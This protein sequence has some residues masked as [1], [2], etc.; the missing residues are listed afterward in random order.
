MKFKISCDIEKAAICLLIV[1]GLSSCRGLPKNVRMVLDAAG[2]NRFE[3]EK[4]IDNYRQL[5]A[6]S[7]KLKAAF[8]LIGSMGD[9]YYYDGELLDAYVGYAKLFG[10]D[11]ARNDIIMDSINDIHG[12]LIINRLRIISDMESLNAEYLINNIDMAFRVW[13]EQ[14][15]N[16]HLSFDQFCEYIL[17]Y[18]V[19][20]ERPEYN[21]SEIY[22][23]YNHL[24]DSVRM[25]GGSATD[26]C[27]VINNELINKG[28]M[29]TLDLASF[30]DFSFSILSEVRKGNCV[31]M[32]NMA[33]MIMRAL[34]IPVTTDMIPRWGVRGNTGHIWNVVLDENGRNIPFV[35]TESNPGEGF[36]NENYYKMT[37]VYRK[38]FA[39]QHVNLPAGRKSADAVPPLFT[40]P[41]LKVVSE[42][43]F[44]QFD[45]GISLDKNEAKSEKNVYACVFKYGNENWEAVDWGKIK[46]SRVVFSGL[47]CNGIPYLPAYFRNG[48]F[49]PANDLFI[50][51]EGGRMVF[52]KADT[53]NKQDMVLHRK[54]PLPLYTGDMAGGK[55]QASDYSDFRTPVDLFVIPENDSSLTWQEISVSPRKPFRYF[56][57]LGPGDS[58]GPIAEIEFYS[59][60][61]RISGS[62][63][64]GIKPGTDYTHSPDKANDGDRLTYFIS[65]TEDD[66]WI[67]IDCG[68]PLK[69]TRIRYLPHNDDNNVV[70]GHQYELVYWGDKKWVSAGTKIAVMDNYLEYKDI[71]S[72]AIYLLRDLTKGR[73]VR[74]FTYENGEQ[75]WW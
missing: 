25:T 59:G 66:A 53:C 40:D 28:W 33:T 60:P 63:M 4:V 16:R 51:M 12:P 27:I 54:Y 69:L 52:P 19:G 14:P 37:V 73:Q 38:Y 48:S 3:L 67:G 39:C 8:F 72:G 26:A 11:E 74:L 29:F 1:I 49:Y 57:Y 55:F 30:P 41:H 75:V 46:K 44:D 47:S 31:A 23:Q 9:K 15:W 13:D 56:R 21:R 43:Y 20:N 24:L 58:K 68:S 32:T 35:G 61:E 18:R 70:N 42:E 7:L 17:P 5:P 50:F 10:N 45:A 65:D 2:D 64:C 71:P 34:G 62:I 6:D 22:M 36:H